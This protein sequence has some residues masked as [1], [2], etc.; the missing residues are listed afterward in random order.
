[1][2][3]GQLTQPLPSASCVLSGPL[4][5][6]GSG[7]VSQCGEPQSPEISGAALSLAAVPSLPRSRWVACVPGKKRMLSLGGRRT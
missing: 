1:M 2:N 3:L 7:Q 4:G 6:L 5:S